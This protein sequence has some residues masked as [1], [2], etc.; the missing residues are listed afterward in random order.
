MKE[1]REH[2]AELR[3]MFAENLAQQS[4]L[5]ATIQQQQQQQLAAQQ[6]HMQDMLSNTQNCSLVPSLCP[7]VPPGPRCVGP[8]CGTTEY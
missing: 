1:L 3:T 8:K 7:S 5:M 4:Q 6:Q 2:N